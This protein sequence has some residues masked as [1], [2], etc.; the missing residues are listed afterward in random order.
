MIIIN[1][2]IFIVVVLVVC[3]VDLS[4]IT[5][6][7]PTERL[8]YDVGED[9]DEQAVTEQE[10]SG[11]FEQFE[12]DIGLGMSGPV[13]EPQPGS[14]QTIDSPPQHSEAAQKQSQF[15]TNDFEEFGDDGDF[16]ELF[17]DD[18][19]DLHSTIDRNVSPESIVNAVVSQQTS[20]PPVVGIDQVMKTLASN[21]KKN[22]KR[23]GQNETESKP[24][25]VGMKFNDTETYE[26]G[27]SMIDAVF[28]GGDE[29]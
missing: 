26:D 8:L 19:L 10:P 12:E 23:A 3:S 17:D 24:K 14:Q 27:D 21:E 11:E 1:A 29:S 20:S 15:T 13:T 7:K 18:D 16:N 2:I 9:V 5:L 25:S 28:N 4:S 6:D 22:Q